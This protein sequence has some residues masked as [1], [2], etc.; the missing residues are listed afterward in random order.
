MSRSISSSSSS[1]FSD[2]HEDDGWEDAEP[3]EEELQI[4]SLFDDNVFSDAKSMVEYCK[5]KYGFDFVGTQKDLG[6]SYC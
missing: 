3:D 1:E 4:V 2:L 6:M 5:E